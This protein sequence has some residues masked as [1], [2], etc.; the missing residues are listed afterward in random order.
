[1]QHR[2]GEHLIGLACPVSLLCLFLNPLPA[3]ALQVP[4]ADRETDTDA[5]CLVTVGGRFLCLLSCHLVPGRPQSPLSNAF[6]ALTVQRCTVSSWERSWVAAVRWLRWVRSPH[7]FP[8][9]HRAVSSTEPC[10]QR[11]LTA[12]QGVNYSSSASQGH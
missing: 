1:M 4:E 9:Q 12:A 2:G 3:L 6:R 10:R 7:I 8:P 5:S 11:Q